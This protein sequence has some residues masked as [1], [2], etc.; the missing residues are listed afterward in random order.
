MCDLIA[1]AILCP[2]RNHDRLHIYHAISC[3]I[4]C[5]HWGSYSGQ[6]I[7]HQIASAIWWK[8]ER[9]RLL[10]DTKL[11]I[12]QIAS[13]ICMQ[14]AHAIAHQIA[15]LTS[16]LV[17]NRIFLIAGKI[18]E[19]FGSYHKYLCQVRGRDLASSWSLK[20]VLLVQCEGQG[21]FIHHPGMWILK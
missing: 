1:D 16:P 11:Q 21:D 15:R 10:S 6:K 12:H 4:S 17:D 18:F 19:L 5:P 8:K 14:I 2:T 20:Y 9:K 7:A 3:A 13:A